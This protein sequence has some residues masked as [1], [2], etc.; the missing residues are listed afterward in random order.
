MLYRFNHDIGSPSPLRKSFS[1][2]MEDCRFL[3]ADIIA[4][5][6][7]NE[8]IKSE[9]AM[10]VDGYMVLCE[11]NEKM[12]GNAY[13]KTTDAKKWFA[14]YKEKWLSKNKPSELFKLE[15]MITYIDEN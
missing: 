2:F 1:E 3:K 15:E 6:H 11:L 12:L 13:E 9:M 8:E 5:E 10:A 7:M 14:S 4:C